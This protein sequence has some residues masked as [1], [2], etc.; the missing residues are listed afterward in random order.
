MPKWPFALVC[1][2]AFAEM[3]VFMVLDTIQLFIDAKRLSD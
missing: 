1:L 2:I 3:T